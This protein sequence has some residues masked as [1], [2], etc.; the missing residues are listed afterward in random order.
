M[1]TAKTCPPCTQ[2]CD[3]GDACPTRQACELPELPFKPRY[4][5]RPARRINLRRLANW[6]IAILVVCLY[7]YVQSRDNAYELRATA[8]GDAQAQAVREIHKDAA[9][10]RMCGTRIVHWTVDGQAVC[11]PL[12]SQQ[13]IA[14]NP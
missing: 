2:D 12:H 11:V 1:S 8:A 7:A 4:T 3:Q 10:A 5:Q 6:L 13:A 14:S 9:A